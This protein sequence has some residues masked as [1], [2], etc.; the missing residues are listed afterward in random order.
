MGRKQPKTWREFL[1]WA[2]EQAD[3]QG[4]PLC[5]CGDENCMVGLS[6]R[7]PRCNG[8]LRIGVHANAPTLIMG[9]EPCGESFTYL[10]L[11][12]ERH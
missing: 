12:E 2:R 11:V 8:E 10:R 6:T 5:Q 1:A 4:E 7:C 3:K 9:C